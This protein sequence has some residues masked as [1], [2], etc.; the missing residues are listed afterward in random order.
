MFPLVDEYD[1]SE[2]L[3]SPWNF[4]P[5]KNELSRDYL[6]LASCIYGLAVA[7]I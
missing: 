6:N 3:Y 2:K 4:F 5:A 7:K 1:L